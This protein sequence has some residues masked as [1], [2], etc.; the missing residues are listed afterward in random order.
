MNDSRQKEILSFFAKGNPYGGAKL[1]DKDFTKEELCELNDARYITRMNII[2]LQYV[3]T[4]KGYRCLR[5]IA[6]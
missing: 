4:I 2:P 6:E 5:G 3:I 1:Q